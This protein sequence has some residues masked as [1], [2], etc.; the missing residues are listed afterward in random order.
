MH[1]YDGIVV[2]YRFCPA[3]QKCVYGVAEHSI[4]TMQTQF[5]ILTSHRKKGTEWNEN[6]ILGSRNG[7]II[8]KICGRLW[9]SERKLRYILHRLHP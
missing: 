6:L 5:G 1:V 8:A 2:G 3:P 9:Q 7:H 4:H